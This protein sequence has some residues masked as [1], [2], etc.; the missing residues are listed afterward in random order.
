MTENK[1]TNDIIKKIKKAM[2]SAPDYDE[3]LSYA[4]ELDY[5]EDKHIWR[6]Q[7]ESVFY[8]A[9]LIR[10][11]LNWMQKMRSSNNIDELST[12][13][14]ESLYRNYGEICNPEL[15]QYAHSGTKKLINEYLDEIETTMWFICDYQSPNISLSE[16]ISRFKQAQ[17]IFG[18]SALM[19]S[20]GGAFGIYHL[21]VVKALWKQKLLPKII[22]GS[23]M[24]SIV[25]AGVCARTDHE[26][27]DF[28][29]H[30]EN[31]YRKALKLANIKQ[32]FHNQLIMNQEQ[33]F[34]H[35]Q[36][37]VGDFTFQ[38]AF[39]KSGRILNITVSPTRTRQKP[40]L[41]NYITTP[42]VMITYSALASCAI[43]CVFSPVLLRAKDDYGLQIPYM[44]TEKWIDGS[45]HSDIPM[46]RISRIHNVNHFIVSQANPHV[47]PFI[48]HRHEKGIV[49]FLKHL[50]S[51]M[52][53][54]HTA[55]LLEVARDM[56]GNQSWRPL[57][58][59]AYAI[60]KQTYLGDINIH[61]P[62]NPLLYR[63][64][65]SNP[66]PKDLDMYI[67]L[68]ERATWP[69][70]SAIRDQTRISHVFEQ[71]IQKLEKLYNVT[72]K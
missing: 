8:H 38:E 9:K 3:W 69:R 15:Y 68:G 51:S 43:P 5:I 39:T 67:K 61:F 57:L 66:S 62:F 17:K 54:A 47:L 23:S 21:G 56:T 26:L 52:I 31:I 50:F 35:I 45:V 29:T 13:I 72:K 1:Q 4:T 63:K 40:R 53:H 65:A 22:S 42:H 20:G 49:P 71:I 37:N 16:K 27:D 18:T 24:G 41:L 48:T 32:I 44:P 64:I 28:L 58:D 10:Q 70:I 25:A 30:P 2:N 60:S 12:F 7:D 34:K 46:M 19:L 59:K 55:E 33:L 14:Q 6:E 36:I 11:H